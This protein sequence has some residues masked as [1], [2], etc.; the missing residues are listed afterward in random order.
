[1]KFDAHWSVYAN[2]MTL[3]CDVFSL[4]LQLVQAH[5]NLL[6]ICVSL[7][8]NDVFNEFFPTMQDSNGSQRVHRVVQGTQP[9]RVV[10]EMSKSWVQHA[11]SWTVRSSSRDG[12]E[13][14]CS[15]RGCNGM[16][17]IRQN[18]W[19][20]GSKLSIE[21]IL[22]LTYAWAHKFTASQAVHETSL[23]DET[24]ST[25]TVVDWYNY[26]REV[27]ADRIMN[28]HAG[29]IGGTGRTVEI[30]ESKF[31]KMKYH[32]GRPIEGKWVF[33]GICRETK[34]CFLVPVERRDRDTLLPI[35]RAHILP[36]TRV[37]SDLW[38]AYACLKNEGYDLIYIFHRQ[39][40]DSHY[41]GHPSFWLLFE[42]RIFPCV[43]YSVHIFHV[44]VGRTKGQY[45]NMWIR[46]SGR[47]T[48]FSTRIKR[49]AW[50]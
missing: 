20:S 23:D 1:M 49:H 33:G 10:C 36:G 2:K 26:C 25:E 30:D 46:T 16:A 7:S 3:F 12:C 35:I 40:R 21:K 13:W 44:R 32:R 19:F 39:R 28:H 34:A 42:F 31:G 5:L 6:T 18:S 29:P 8:F 9:T 15:K 14:R 37:M 47:Y 43:V 17:S 41:R 45:P 22:A 24:T 38:K 11:L 4:P 50:K 27:C 48:K